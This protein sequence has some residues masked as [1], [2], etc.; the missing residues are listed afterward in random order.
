M[1]GISGLAS[2]Y[3]QLKQAEAN[4]RQHEMYKQWAIDKA[5]QTLVASRLKRANGDKWYARHVPLMKHTR[6]Y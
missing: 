2:H 6:R 4:L 3:G 5:I 1:L